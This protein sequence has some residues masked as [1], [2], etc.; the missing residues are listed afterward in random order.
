M[1]N[2]ADF[3]PSIVINSAPWYMEW[4]SYAPPTNTSLGN[5]TKIGVPNPVG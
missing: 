2:F 3:Y 4:T 5:I 1:H